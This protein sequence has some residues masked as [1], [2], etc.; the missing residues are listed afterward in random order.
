MKDSFQSEASKEATESQDA[1]C[2][3]PPQEAGEGDEQKTES[4]GEKRKRDVNSP[5]RDRSQKVRAKSPIKEDEPAID[6]EK[7]QLNWCK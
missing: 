1:A 3:K 4:K 2:K 7:V 5:D 6:N